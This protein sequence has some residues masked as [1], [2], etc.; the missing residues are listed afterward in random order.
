MAAASTTGAVDI[1]ATADTIVATA[2]VMDTAEVTAADA[3]THMA[4]RFT[5][6]EAAM[7]STATLAADSTVTPEEG[8]TAAVGSMEAPEADFTEVVE[9]MGADTGN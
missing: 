3:A 8:F 6:V 2:M 7:D 1:T 4:V 5:N 9:A